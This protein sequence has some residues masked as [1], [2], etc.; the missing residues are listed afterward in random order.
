MK[1]RTH[2]RRRR[3][4]THTCMHC[5]QRWTTNRTFPCGAVER[6]FASNIQS[7]NVLQTNPTKQS[8]NWWVGNLYSVWFVLRAS[9]TAGQIELLCTKRAGG[10][11]MANANDE[12]WCRREWMA[13][14]HPEAK[15]DFHLSR[16]ISMNGLCVLRASVIN[17]RLWHLITNRVFSVQVCYHHMSLIKSIT[18]SVTIPNKT[19]FSQSIVKVFIS[20]AWVCVCLCAF[21][22][23]C[24]FV[25]TC[26]A[27]QTKLLAFLER[28]RRTKIKKAMEWNLI[29]ISYCCA[30]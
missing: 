7:H 4:H 18:M 12:D 1:N 16:L 21:V 28:E 10:R 14:R 15:T 11:K 22:C 27:A 25:V 29:L 8:N 9:G 6:D 26:F 19:L 20:H 2:V 17:S 23:V 13:A 30:Y 3:T 24:V 5:A